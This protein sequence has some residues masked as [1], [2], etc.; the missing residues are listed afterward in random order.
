MVLDVEDGFSS[1]GDPSLLCRDIIRECSVRKFDGILCDFTGEPSPF[2]LQVVTQLSSIATQRS[3]NLYIPES[4]ASKS[5]SSMILLSSDIFSGSL[6]SLLRRAA[7]D[8]GAER[9]A[10]VMQR[11]ANEF[12]LPAGGNQGKHLTRKELSELVQ[13]FSPSVF[14]DHDLC[15]HYFTY[16]NR[17]AAFFVLFDDSGSLLR[18]M[19]LARS[20]GI[21]R[22]ILTFPDVEDILPRLF[23][24]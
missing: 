16:M 20:L 24:E 9:I 13:R 4:F 6:E 1:A 5:K 12:R 2:L 8:Y 23:S 10:L 3:W 15:A 17:N 14:F 11:M 7:G 22:F 21:N 18:K 19:S